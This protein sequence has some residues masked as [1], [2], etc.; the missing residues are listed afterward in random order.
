M[1]IQNH[2]R[3]PNFIVSRSLLALAV[4]VYNISLWTYNGTLTI[5]RGGFV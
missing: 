2:F 1:L 4:Y 3:K 5:G